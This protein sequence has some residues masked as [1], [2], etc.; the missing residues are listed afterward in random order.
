MRPW[1][2]RQAPLGPPPSCTGPAFPAG[3][4]FEAQT[5]LSP[6]GGPLGHFSWPTLCPQGLHTHVG[7][8]PGKGAHGPC[9]L[10]PPLLCEE[11]VHLTDAGGA[12]PLDQACISGPG[13]L[14]LPPAGT[15]HTPWG[16][17]K[18]LGLSGEGRAGWPRAGGGAVTPHPLCSIPAGDK[19]QVGKVKGH[20]WKL[21][22]PARLARRAH[23]SK[24]LE[25]Y[26]LHLEELGV[27][28]EMQAR[29]LV[30]QLWAT[31]VGASGCGCEAV[32]VSVCV[33]VGGGTHTCVLCGALRPRAC[34]SVC[35]GLCVCLY[36]LS[37]GH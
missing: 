29:A 31:Q 12:P 37:M 18:T 8:G 6:L 27:S 22:A 5:H 21:L 9:F 10:S 15:P 23:R 33:C 32:H 20:L 24:W 16:D 11:T 14:E 26:L 17:L 35:M 30:L 3:V 4:E 1:D 28:E 13:P 7:S 19:D 25:S 2:P 36:T 34:E